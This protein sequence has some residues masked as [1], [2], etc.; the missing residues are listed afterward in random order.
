MSWAEVLW[1]LYQPEQAWQVLDVAPLDELS[2]TTGVCAR[3]WP[4]SWSAMMRC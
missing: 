1:N 2:P 3:P 4:G